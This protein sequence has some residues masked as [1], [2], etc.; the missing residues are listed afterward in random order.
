MS[1]WPRTNPDDPWVQMITASLT[2]TSGKP[3]NVVP[4]SSGG[5]PSRLFMD[6]LGVPV[7]WIPNSYAGCNQHAPN[8]H[9]L[10]PLLREGLGL[11]AGLL[12][13]IGAGQR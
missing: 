6:A 4:N 12:W 11:M 8:E 10:A 1:F 5:N 9:A 2:R 3:I 13:D 7:I